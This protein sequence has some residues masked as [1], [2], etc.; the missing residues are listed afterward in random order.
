[1]QGNDLWECIKSGEWATIDGEEPKPGPKKGDIVTCKERRGAWLEF[2]E[3][4]PDK[5][6]ELQYPQRHFRKLEAPTLSE[7]VE[8]MN[9]VQLLNT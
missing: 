9:S 6:G 7:I 3:Y 2:Y 8:A 1:M 4:P 5:D